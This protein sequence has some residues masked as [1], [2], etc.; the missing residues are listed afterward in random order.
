MNSP[1]NKSPVQLITVLSG[2]PLMSGLLWPEEFFVTVAFTTT[3]ASVRH[4]EITITKGVL[5]SAGGTQTY[6]MIHTGLYQELAVESRAL[7]I[8]RVLACACPRLCPERW[9][10]AV[11]LLQIPG[12]PQRPG[13]LVLHLAHLQTCEN[14]YLWPLVVGPLPRHPH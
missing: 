11:H 9:E 14:G 5:E 10:L 2:A 7:H 13:A 1:K 3:E 4:K 6:Q 12:Q 8:F